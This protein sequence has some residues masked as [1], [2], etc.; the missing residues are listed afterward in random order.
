[1]TKNECNW[2]QAGSPTNRTSSANESSAVDGVKFSFT[3]ADG[4]LNDFSTAYCSI[5]VRFTVTDADTG[6]S[7]VVDGSGSIA[8]ETM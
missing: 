8:L 7:T 4:D 5:D 1:M 3:V 6:Q 2:R